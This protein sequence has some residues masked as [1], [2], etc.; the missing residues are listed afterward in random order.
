ME[1]KVLLTD[2][3]GTLKNCE[4]KDVIIPMG[5]KENG[6]KVYEYF[7]NMNHISIAGATRT[8]KSMFA[9]TLIVSL[10]KQLSFDKLDLILIDPKRTEYYE[11]AEKKYHYVTDADWIKNTWMSFENKEPL[12]MT[13]VQAKTLV[14]CLALNYT[15]AVA[16]MGYEGR[17]KPRK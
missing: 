5:V 12:K 7:L 6:E 17:F 16:I 13:E 3:I 15:N 10:T 1:E 4:F 14:E 2:M 8:G 11:Y 9:H